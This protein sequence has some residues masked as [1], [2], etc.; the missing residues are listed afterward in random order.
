[1]TTLA[2]PQVAPDRWSRWSD[3]LNPILVREVQQA[4][5]GRL[6]T[7]SVLFALLVVVVIAIAVAGAENR[8]TEAGRN[9]FDAGLATLV[10]LVLFVVPM[11][12]YQSMRLELRSGIVE[13]LLLSRL[14]PRA[15]LAGKLTAALVQFVLYVSILAPLLAT[16]YLLRGVDLPTIVVSLGFGL[17]FCVAST[18][19]A[20]SAAA[21]GTVP[22]L[23]PVAQ[24]AAAFGFGLLTFGMMTY[25]GSG[26]YV[27]DLG[28]MMRRAEFAAVASAMV[29]CAAAGAVLS[30]LTAQSF[31]LHA[32]EN[33]STGFRVFLFTL[34]LLAVG[35]MLACI[36]PMAWTAV[37]CGIV[38]AATLV[39]TLFGAFFWTEQKALS[40]RVRAHVPQQ[41]LLALLAAPFLPGR[42]RGALCL[43][44]YFALLAVP[45]ALCW[46]VPGAHTFAPGI[47]VADE[48]LGL[49]RMAAMTAAYAVIYLSIAK[50]LRSTMP[51]AVT[52]NHLARFVLPVVL[53]LFVLA[54]VLIDVLTRGGVRSWHIGHV[55]NPFWTIE[56]FAWRPE[57]GPVVGGLVGV[58]GLCVLLQVRSMLHGLR[59][60]QAASAQ[61]RAA[62]RRP[63]GDG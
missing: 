36:E 4:V 45:A 40:P 15:I 39:G 37:L 19:A 54:P 20:I 14:R 61:R 31:L 48:R 21:Q 1:M 32:F 58:A 17:V 25:I 63:D 6:F 34:P 33:R 2:E 29:L 7:L 53:L 8:S 16:G 13:Q 44:L 46:P 51:A 56:R 27:R 55:M 60:V 10:P 35:W 9:V 3:R 18:A 24:I 49:L 41:P 5:K 22:A 52:G 12:A 26:E 47:M 30:S 11:Q 62:L 23:A 50:G 43:L 28:W 57:R 42:D 38:F 59:E